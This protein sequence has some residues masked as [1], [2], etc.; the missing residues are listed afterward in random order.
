MLAAF[1]RATV[2]TFSRHF[3]LLAFLNEAVAVEPTP[4]KDNGDLGLPKWGRDIEIKYATSKEKDLI[5]RALPVFA[6]ACPKLVREHLVD[7]TKITAIIDRD[8]NDLD[9]ASGWRSTV[10]LYFDIAENPT[11]IPARKGRVVELGRQL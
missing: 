1:R 11:T 3:P 10:W 8:V 4:D 6:T 2:P 9:V 7:V 5:A